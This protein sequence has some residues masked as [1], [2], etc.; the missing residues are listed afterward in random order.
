MISIL[1][2]GLMGAIGALVGEAGAWIFCKLTN[3]ERTIVIRRAGI[4]IGVI[5]VFYASSFK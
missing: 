4:V 3:K 5:L 1:I 2:A